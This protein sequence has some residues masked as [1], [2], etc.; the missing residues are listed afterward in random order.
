M[1]IETV[2]FFILALLFQYNFFLDRKVIPM[3]KQDSEKQEIDSDVKAE[4]QR[5]LRCTTSA[6]LSFKYKNLFLAPKIKIYFK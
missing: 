5:T 4:I 2:V 1:A 6:T 3:K